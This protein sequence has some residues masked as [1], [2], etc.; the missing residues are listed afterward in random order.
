MIVIINS[1]KLWC[2]EPNVTGI[3]VLLPHSWEIFFL[4]FNY[5]CFLVSLHHCFRGLKLGIPSLRLVPEQLTLLSIFGVTEF[6]LDFYDIS[7][8]LQKRFREKWQRSL[9]LLP[10]TPHY[11][12]IYGSLPYHSQT[13]ALCLF[14]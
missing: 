2:I 9:L 5:F 4:S 14:L 3:C 13:T 6:R 1:H 8:V 10:I 12:R 7:Y 11:Y